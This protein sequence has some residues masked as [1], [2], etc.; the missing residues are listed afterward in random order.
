MNTEEN[1]SRARLGIFF[2]KVQKQIPAFQYNDIPEGPLC[3][4][5]YVL[6]FKSITRHQDR[7]GIHRG[8]QS[9]RWEETDEYG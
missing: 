1:F 9:R 3:S 4:G 6:L 5:K 2:T 7:C 8:I